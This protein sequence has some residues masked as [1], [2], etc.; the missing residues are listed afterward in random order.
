MSLLLRIVNKLTILGLPYSA[1]LPSW[2]DCNEGRSIQIISFKFILNFRLLL[3]WI[4][5]M[6]HYLLL[7]IVGL[8][9][10]FIQI[11][12]FSSIPRITNEL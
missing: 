1:P 7:W 9:D 5:G 8:E 6:L 2:M 12:N 3:I 10:L 11:S 4:H